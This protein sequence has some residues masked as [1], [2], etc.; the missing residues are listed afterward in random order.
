MARFRFKL[1]WC[2][3]SIVRQDRPEQAI[4]RKKAQAATVAAC[5]SIVFSGMAPVLLVVTGAQRG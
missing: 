1:S 3:L 2:P 4:I 5:A